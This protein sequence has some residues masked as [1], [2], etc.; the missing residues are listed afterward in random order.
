MLLKESRGSSNKTDASDKRHD[1]GL[2]WSVHRINRDLPVH[3]PWV[4]WTDLSITA[5]VAFI[6]LLVSVRSP[7]GSVQQILAVV[8]AG[9]AFYRA[10]TFTHE[11]THMQ[12]GSFQTFRVVWN[13]FIDVVRNAGKAKSDAGR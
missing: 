4:Y 8:L 6:G 9:F 7:V 5:T 12:A 3:K 11:I 2:A 1:A 13:L 10:A